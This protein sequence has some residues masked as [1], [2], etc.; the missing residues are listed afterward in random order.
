MK[1]DF[2][3]QR[4][5]WIRIKNKGKIYSCGFID[6]EKRF[7]FSKREHEHL[8][9]KYNGLG[10]SLV[11][12]ND[13]DRL[14]I[15]RIVFLYEGE[16]ITSTTDQF[17]YRGVKFMDG[18]DEQYILPLDKFKKEKI[19]EE[20]LVLFEENRCNLHYLNRIPKDYQ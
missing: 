19:E 15:Q 9:R 4:R 7:Y 3:I 10:V 13:L 16:F 17:F 8:F 18:N 1:S 6:Y 2:P 5:Q 14:G 20:Q 12:L 11:I